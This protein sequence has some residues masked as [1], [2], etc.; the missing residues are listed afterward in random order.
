M[1]NIG[2]LIFIFLSQSGIQTGTYLKGGFFKFVVEK[3]ARSE[4]I[5]SEGIT[6][7]ADIC[8]D[9]LVKMCCRN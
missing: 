5:Y 7:S 1:L 3:T 8:Y 2:R 4:L 6:V 9:P